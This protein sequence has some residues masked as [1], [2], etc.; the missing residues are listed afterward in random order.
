MKL[1]TQAVH[2]G[3]GSDPGTGAVMA[4]I[5]LSTT[6]ER[7]ADGSFPQGYSYG[8]SGNPN[9]EA[10]ESR[11]RDLEGGADAA[12]FASGSVATMAL[13]QALRPGD[14]VIASEDLYFGIRV[15]LSEFFAPWG[16]ESQ[17]VD[18]S[19]LSA[20]T[21]AIQDNTRLV[22]LE[23]PSNPLLKIAD[24]EQIVT[25]ARD[26]GAYV[27]VDNTMATPV[28]QRPFTL[29]SD[30]VIHS[31]T[32]S[33]SGH[34]D[35]IGGVVIAR[36]ASDYFQRIRR[37]QT[38]GGAVPSP[39]DCWLTLRGIQTLPY[40]V[41]AQAASALKIAEFLEDHPAVD[42]VL[43]PGLASHPGHDIAMRQ[44][45][46]YGG[47]L[48]VQVRGGRDEAMET[49]ARVQLFTRA[50]SFGGT[51]SNLEHRASIEENSSTPENL[52]RVSIG[53]EHVDDLIADL[54]QAL[55]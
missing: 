43:Y 45:S 38:I 22:L 28:Q 36:E 27:A 33:L 12:V 39:F 46:S 55:G 6:Y 25:L 4:P 9:R 30:F 2:G 23:S 48:S 26:V 47:V 40:R 17:F 52:L 13:F 15:Q 21:Q 5:Q 3:Q 34:G 50:T 44:M 20:L 8:R 32:K 42:R 19:D 7:A 51:H 29:G 16:L 37:I 31:T 35:V 14:Q 1:E 54:D 11:L 53:L 10:L 49:A 41:H 18:T 24:I